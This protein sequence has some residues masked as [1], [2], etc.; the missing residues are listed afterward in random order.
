[1]S[2]KAFQEPERRLARGL[3]QVY[4]GEGKGKTTAAFGLAL[5][6]A[7]WGLRVKVLQFL[8]GRKSGEVAAAERAGIAVEQFGTAEWVNLESPTEAD[9][10]RAQAGLAAAREAL[11]DVDLLVL[12][13]AN[14]ALSAGLLQLDQVLALLEA[15]P[16]GVEVV[17]TGRGAPAALLARAD[18]VT[19]M[20]QIKHPF[21]SGAAAREGIE[22]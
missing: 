17:L 10:Q 4:T 16:Q 2:G 9:R 12:D 7:G 6:A 5:R 1:V 14:V 3:V 18:L 15:R 20:R 11:D 8:K 19:E 13:E 21:Q 22:F